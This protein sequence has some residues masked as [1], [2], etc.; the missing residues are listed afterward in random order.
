M[1]TVVVPPL[2]VAVVVVVDATLLPPLRLVVQGA[3]LNEE[4]AELTGEGSIEEAESMQRAESRELIEPSRL[5]VVVV[6]EEEM[7]ALI[8]GCWRH[9]SAV[10]RL[11]EGGREG[12]RDGGRDGAREGGRERGRRG[13][14]GKKK[15]A[16]EKNQLME[17][18]YTYILAITDGQYLSTAAVQTNHVPNHQHTHIHT[19]THTHTYMHTHMH[20]HTHVW[21][22]YTRHSKSKPL[23]IKQTS[24]TPHTTHHVVSCYT[25][26]Y[27]AQPYNKPR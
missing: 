20:T 14:G 4:E 1:G 19:H 5:L 3:G 2:V 27:T 16:G 9:S 8:Q 18:N 22:T 6:E 23:N 24:H 15:S 25:Y 17:D 26:T 12:G 7:W 10:R 21:A 11:L 13:E